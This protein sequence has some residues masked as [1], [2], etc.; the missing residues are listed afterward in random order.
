MNF[1]SNRSRAAFCHS[2]ACVLI[3]L[4]AAMP[5]SSPAQVNPQIANCEEIKDEDSKFQADLCSAHL[6]CKLVFGIQK[7]CAKA[8]QFLGNLK[9]AIGEGVQGFFGKKKEVTPDAVFQAT[10]NDKTRAAQDMPE[11][12]RVT[13]LLT[14]GVKV[15]PSNVLSGKG[16]N[17]STW[18]YYGDA[19][20][21]RANGFGTRIFSSGQVERGNYS[22]DNLNGLTDRVFANGTREIGV[23]SEGKLQGVGVKASTD[24]D[25]SVGVFSYGNLQNGRKELWDGRAWEGKFSDDGVLLE[26]KIYRRPGELLEEG[27][28]DRFG[29]LSVGKRYVSGSTIEVDE[30]RRQAAV[31]AIARDAEEQRKRN[32]EIERVAAEQRKRADEERAAQAFRDSL[33]TMNPGEL[34]ARADELSSQ[35]DKNRAREVLRSLISRF[36]D[37]RLAEN[38]ATQLSSASNSAVRTTTSINAAGTATATDSPPSG[39]PSV[40]NGGNCK[41]EL[42]EGE[43]ITKALTPRITAMSSNTDKMQAIMWVIR[44]RLRIG[45][46]FC[47]GDADWA[48]LRASLSKSY[49]ATAQNCAQSSTAGR[50]SPQRP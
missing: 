3:V 24:G 27:K 1:F 41:E 47:Q 11:V 13:K 32:A 38:A 18:V 14:D 31:D 49:D 34:F 30:P 45:D 42:A 50:C 44:E 15:A 37:H 8:K 9:A 35:G 7:T 22:D 21:G 12:D 46:K 20:E 28:F 10:L 26:G 6:G 5:I 16:T 48:S 2:M 36:P 40:S 4:F 43:R 33:R 25:L 23:T 19:R 17:D 29:A 39:T